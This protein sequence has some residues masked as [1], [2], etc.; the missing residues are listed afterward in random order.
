MAYGMLPRARRRLARQGQAEDG[1]ILIE[2]LVSALILAIVAGAVLA[3]ITATTRSAASE[4]DHS[5][6]FGIAQEEQARMRTMRISALKELN[7]TPRS[8]T[9]GGTIFTVESRGKFVNSTTGT[10][11]CS[12]EG[13]SA[14]YVEITSTVS[15]ETLLNPVSIHS[16]VSPSNGSLDPSHGTFAFQ[17]KNAAGE[18]LSNVSITGSGA[19][20]FN[21]FTDENGCATFA[22]VPSGNYSVTT[23]APGRINPQG[24]ESAT[25]ELNVEAS[26]TQQKTFSFDRPGTIKASFYYKEP[27]GTEPTAAIDSM[28][29][30]NTENELE[31]TTVWT[32]GHALLSTPL[33]SEKVYPFKTT[34]Y[35]VYAGSCKTNSPDPKNEGINTTAVVKIPVTGGSFTERTIQ[36]PALN[37]VVT[38]EGNKLEGATVVATDKSCQYNTV[39]VARL[40]TTDKVGHIA[41]STA[42]ST[43]AVGLPY[44]EYTVC[45]STPFTRRSGGHNITEYHRVEKTISVKNLGS[46]TLQKLELSTSGSSS[47]C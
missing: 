42:A 38:F 33:M 35:S 16:I 2:V 6:A 46:P 34:P 39:N 5:V 31:A 37:A 14:D 28:E 3:L 24:L 20:N 4:R 43:E 18:P 1:F 19:G 47:G 11:S 26:A 45:A 36:V 44:G 10:S 29:L 17:A 15:S 22:D 32:P 8:V 40:F 12:G 21:G 27:N 9:V 41:T 23:S 30:F 13:A 7:G 25:I